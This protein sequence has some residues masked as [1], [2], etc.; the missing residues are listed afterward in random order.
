MVKKKFE[1]ML[2]KVERIRVVVE[3]T[4]AEAARLT[5]LEK[6]RRGEADAAEDADVTVKGVLEL[7]TENP[8]KPLCLCASVPLC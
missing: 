8:S 3:A 1:V 7:D 6:E 2:E 5:A 4:D